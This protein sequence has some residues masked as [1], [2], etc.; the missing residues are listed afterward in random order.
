[1]FYLTVSNGDILLASSGDTNI[2]IWDMSDFSQIKKISQAHDKTIWCLK[3]LGPNSGYF[4]SASEDTIIKIWDTRVFKFIRRLIGI[5]QGVRSLEILTDGRLISSSLYN[6]QIWD[7]NLATAEQSQSA[8]ILDEYRSITLL[9]NGDLAIVGVKPIILFWTLQNQVQQLSIAG[10][11]VL[12]SNT[13]FTSVV[14]SPNNL[15]ATFWGSL[16]SLS[17]SETYT[18][19]GNIETNHT[20]SSIEAFPYGK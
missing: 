8:Q 10:N 11:N 19:I 3:W 4:A 14:K 18:L 9:N 16:I 12:P 17:S 1:M 2:I 13:S 7:L 6:L 15:V 5:S 20:I